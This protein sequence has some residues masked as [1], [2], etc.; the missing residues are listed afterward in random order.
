V[1]LAAAAIMARL[2]FAAFL[3]GAESFRHPNQGT[4]VV[5]QDSV[6]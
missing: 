2:I 4:E 5:F 3:M 6:M 1:V